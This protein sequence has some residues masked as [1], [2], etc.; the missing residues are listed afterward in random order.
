MQPREQ[1]CRERPLL[2]Q[3]EHR[4]M[5]PQPDGVRRRRIERRREPRPKGGEQQEAADEAQEG[6]LPRDEAGNGETEQ[7]ER[8]YRNERGD[9][10]REPVSPREQPGR[11]FRPSEEVL[12]R[13]LLECSGTSRASVQ[14]LT[15]FE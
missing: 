1:R 6:K 9:P 3:G 15:Q 2:E 8:E 14:R 13:T 11:A 12:E 10:I 7:P 4:R 5:L